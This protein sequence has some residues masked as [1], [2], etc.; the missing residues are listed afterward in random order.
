[1]GMSLVG[2]LHMAD[3]IVVA[4]VAA[5]KGACPTQAGGFSGAAPLTGG[6]C[7]SRADQ[8]RAVGPEKEMMG[9]M[10]L[11]EAL[12]RADEMDVDVVM[13]NPKADPPVVRLVDFSK[14]RYEQA[15]AVKEA[16]KKQRENR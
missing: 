4:A 10:T 15:R 7:G 1:M 14:F 9:V 11:S 12:D 6:G 3:E 2:A 13:I 5:R 16:S 8:V